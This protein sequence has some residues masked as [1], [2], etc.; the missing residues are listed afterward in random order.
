MTLTT[1]SNRKLR[2]KGLAW[3][4]QI[5]LGLLS[6]IKEHSSMKLGRTYDKED[7][8]EAIIVVGLCYEDRQGRLSI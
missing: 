3:V 7:Y 1:N 5:V 4:A 2:L 8:E 6:W